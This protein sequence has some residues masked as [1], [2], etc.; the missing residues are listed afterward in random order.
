MSKRQQKKIIESNES[1]IKK[2]SFFHHVTYKYTIILN[3]SIL[4]YLRTVEV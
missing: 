1:N 4:L 2:I 3:L